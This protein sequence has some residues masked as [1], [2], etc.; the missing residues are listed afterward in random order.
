MNARL[1]GT[2]GMLAS[3]G[4]HTGV[5][6][7]CGMKF[8]GPVA[9]WMWRTVY[10][11]KLPRLAKKLRVMAGWTLDLF[12]GRDI[13]QTITVEVIESTAEKIARV[14]ALTISKPGRVESRAFITNESNTYAIR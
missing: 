14:R 7:F 6:M 8:S 3:L 12:F 5:A 13:E 2:I 1:L 9:W 11:A 4:H 10:L